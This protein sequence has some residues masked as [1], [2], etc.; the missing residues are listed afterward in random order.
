MEYSCLLCRFT[1]LQI[2]TNLDYMGP[3]APS[4]T[5]YRE[6]HSVVGHSGQVLQCFPFPSVSF[7]RIIV[8]QNC[9][10]FR[11]FTIIMGLIS[12]IYIFVMTL[13]KISVL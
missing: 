3:R 1:Y 12:Q 11:K 9:F 5:A 13:E 2:Q 10:I 7:G 4:I 6:I 8:K